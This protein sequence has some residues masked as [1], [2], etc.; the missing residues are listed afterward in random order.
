MYFLTKSRLGTTCFR[1]IRAIFRKVT[2][3]R[4]IFRKSI[5]ACK[6]TLTAYKGSPRGITARLFSK[7]SA[8]F[9]VFLKLCRTAHVWD[10]HRLLGKI[11]FFIA[12]SEKVQG[13]AHY[14][15]LFQKILPSL[16]WKNPALPRKTS[17]NPSVSWKTSLM[18]F[19][20]K[21]DFFDKTSSRSS[22]KPIST[23]EKV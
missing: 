19:W 17:Q 22:E 10:F 13:R 2:S 1:K 8:D 23:S 21:Q 14:L 16:P 12:C 4:S 20:A 5:L 9:W 15:R 11:A 6:I 3:I 18:A 7:I